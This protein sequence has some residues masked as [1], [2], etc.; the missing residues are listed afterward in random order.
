MLVKRSLISV[1]VLA[2]LTA[3]A[4]MEVPAAPAT[5]AL[6][7]TAT[8]PPSPTTAPSPTSSPSLA[9]T[10]P[11]E[12]PTVPPT[13]PPTV[14]EAPVDLLARTRAEA[15]AQAGLPETELTLVRAE[16][17]TWNDGALGCPQ[18]GMFYTQALVDGY[19]IQWQTGEG[20]LYDYR[21][22]QSGAFR[23]CP[24]PGP[25]GLPEKLPTPTPAAP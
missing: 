10:L 23:L 12:L 16:A 24:A 9:A 4:P 19:W 2:G 6:S 15:A 8:R 5:A 25:L 22:T 18:R 11:P 20:R 14:G 7:A 17:V 3:C 13:E 21:A 1:L